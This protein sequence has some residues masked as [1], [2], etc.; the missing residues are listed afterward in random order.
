MNERNDR[1]EW[2]GFVAAAAATANQKKLVSYLHNNFIVFFFF[3]LL[4]MN[5]N[6]GFGSLQQQQQQ[7]NDSIKVLP[8]TDSA[9][10]IGI[11]LFR[12]IFIGLMWSC[13]ASHGV[14]RNFIFSPPTTKRSNQLEKF[15]F[16]HTTTNTASMTCDFFSFSMKSDI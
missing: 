1:N 7:L 8:E 14:Q 3:S 4:S 15:L 5:L 13:V 11:F 16:A 10:L 2:A 6:S 12:L 9:F